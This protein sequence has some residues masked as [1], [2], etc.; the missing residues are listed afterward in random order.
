MRKYSTIPKSKGFTTDPSNYSLNPY[1]NLHR[2]GLMLAQVRRSNILPPIKKHTNV[3]TNSQRLA[4]LTSLMEEHI[5]PQPSPQHYPE[6][7]SQKSQLT[8]M[9]SPE[10]INIA[11][12]RLGPI[13]GKEGTLNEIFLERS[14]RVN[15]YMKYRNRRSLIERS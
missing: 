5:L 1:I 8:W 9:Y 11:R 7:S 2:D 10:S 4:P 13:M 6:P 15:F 14:K 3:T 12:T